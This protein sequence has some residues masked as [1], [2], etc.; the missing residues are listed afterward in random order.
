MQHRFEYLGSVFV[1][2]LHVDTI[3][4]VFVEKTWQKANQVNRL[5]SFIDLRKALHFE[6]YVG[7][8]IGTM[9]SL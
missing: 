6:T 3:V 2:S 1:Y 5:K 4:Q 9:N 7:C 8:I